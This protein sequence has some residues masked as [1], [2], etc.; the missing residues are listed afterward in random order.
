MG[1][2]SKAL[3]LLD[4]F[5]VERPEIGLSELA[6]L[7]GLNKTTVYR[8]MTELQESRFV[9]QVNNDR[10]YRIGTAVIRLSALRDAVVPLR[11]TAKQTVRDLA[12]KTGETAHFSILDGGELSTLTYAYSTDHGTRV[13][14]DD[15]AILPIHA[16]SSGL[17]VMAYSSDDFVDLILEKPLTG[18]TP[19][20][21]VDPWKLR[22][23]IARTKSMGVAEY[24]S[25]FE[26]DVHSFASPVFNAKRRVY[27]AIAVAAPVNRVGASNSEFLRSAVYDAA[28]ALTQLT[29]GFDPSGLGHLEIKEKP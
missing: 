11:E 12:E 27:G 5:T 16:T 4:Y 1:T 23:M 25:G 9:E 15:A 10:T 20:T 17:A 6:R 14:M 28:R 24:V 8:M 21:V 13:M 2:V 29:G 22:Q 19:Y 7:S 18:R 3:T 26:S